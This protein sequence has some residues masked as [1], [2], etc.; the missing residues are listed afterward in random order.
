[1]G[2]GCEGQTLSGESGPGRADFEGKF[3]IVLLDDYLSVD[4]CVGT[5]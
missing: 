2:Y 1:M 3:L 5:I 4:S